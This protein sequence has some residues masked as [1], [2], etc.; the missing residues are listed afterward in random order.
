MNKKAIRKPSPVKVVMPATLLDKNDISKNTDSK[1]DQDFPGFPHGHSVE[2]IINPST[3]AER[4]IADI[5]NKDGEKD[6]EASKKIKR[7]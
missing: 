2:K 5:D 3:S 1:I 7:R 4:K 6:N